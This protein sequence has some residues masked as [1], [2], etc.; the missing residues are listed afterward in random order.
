[1]LAAAE[2]EGG[3]HND[4]ASVDGETC[5]A[6]A[7]LDGAT[8]GHG[9][10]GLRH[11][12]SL[13]CGVISECLTE[14]QCVWTA[15]MLLCQGAKWSLATPRSPTGLQYVWTAWTLP[16]KVTTAWSL[17]MSGSHL[18][19]VTEHLD[20]ITCGHCKATFRHLNTRDHHCIGD[21]PT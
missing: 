3:D 7:E 14:S 12:G 15:W 11:V 18:C 4:G 19:P 9:A 2:P 10:S 5:K 1:M 8:S 13:P 6:A 20:T 21:Q 16:L 17:I